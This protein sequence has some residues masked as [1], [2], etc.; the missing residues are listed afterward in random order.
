MTISLYTNNSE[1]NVLDKNITPITT[2]SG[3]LR[4][5]CSIENPIIL[6]EI[7][8]EEMANANYMYIEEFKRYYFINKTVVRNNLW[9]VYGTVDVLM[10]FKEE[11]KACNALCIRNENDI[12]YY[13]NDDEKMKYADCHV[14]YKKFPNQFDRN[15]DRF[16]LITA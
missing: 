1:N 13:I 14:V 7:T 10:S 4:D 3:T 12:S 15:N 16:I 9:R 6:L 2:L 11:I 5:E 8:G